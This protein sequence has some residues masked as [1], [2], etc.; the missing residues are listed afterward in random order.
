MAKYRINYYKEDYIEV[1]AKDSSE[2]RRKAIQG[3]PM[4]YDYYETE[5]IDEFEEEDD[6]EETEPPHY[7][8]LPNSI[9]GQMVRKMIEFYERQTLLKENRG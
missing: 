3:A 8:P 1:E 6:E 4:D 9:G 2:L 7:S 5:E